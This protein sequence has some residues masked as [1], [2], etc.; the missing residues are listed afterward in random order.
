MRAFISVCALA[1]VA[2]AASQTANY[3]YSVGGENWYEVY[4]YEACKKSD[5]SQQS[6]IN[7]DCQVEKCQKD[8]ALS[9]SAENYGASNKVSM[10]TENGKDYPAVNMQISFPVSATQDGSGP[11]P[12]VMDDDAVTAER[13]RLHAINEAWFDVAGNCDDQCKIAGAK[14]CRPQG[15]ESNSAWETALLA[16]PYCD[17]GTY[18]WAPYALTYIN[19]DVK[20]YADWPEKNGVSYGWSANALADIWQTDFTSNVKNAVENFQATPVQM[21]I[22]TPSEHH[23]NGK[24]YDAEIHWVHA[25]IVN[26]EYNYAVIGFMFD[27]EEGDDSGSFDLIAELLK[28][29]NEQSPAKYDP[30]KESDNQ[31]ASNSA[32]DDLFEY[33]MVDVGK[34]F[35]QVDL[36]NFYHYTGS[37]T[38]PPCTEGVQFYIMKQIQPLTEAQ[39]E[40][41][42]KYTEDYTPH[43][44][45]EEPE[46]TANPDNAAGNNRAIQDL[47]GRTIYES[48]D[49]SQSNAMA[50]LAMVS[51][52]V[53]LLAF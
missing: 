34:F 3:D 1:A 32:N 36:V 12:A 28:T 31:D 8:D 23:F 37:F 27:V 49:P 33:P 11:W 39:L 45:N 5:K 46:N 47:N 52:L 25:H 10:Y 18:E 16:E 51:P 9:V 21:H 15:N 44:D 2:S 38:T 40:N 20:S 42:K 29:Y 48:V 41:I 4:N 30:S 7:L 24:S 22:H 50:L 53:A 17:K 35:E 19:D 6:P 13:T 26:G 43:E 14:P